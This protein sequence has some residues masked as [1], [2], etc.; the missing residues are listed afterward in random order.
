[1]KSIFHPQSLLF[2]PEKISKNHLDKYDSL[3]SNINFSP[4]KDPPSSKGRNPFPKD[5]LLSCLCPCQRE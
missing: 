2:S 3:F 5:V 1:M 4:L